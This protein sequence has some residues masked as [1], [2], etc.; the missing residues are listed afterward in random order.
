MEMD[1]LINVSLYG[2]GSRRARLRAE[3]IYCNHANECSAYKDG[4][5]FRVTTLFG[6]RC[7]FGRISCVD[8]CTK[9][10]KTY[11]KVY[12]ETKA[13][14]KYG[15]LSYPYDTYIIR[16]GDGAFLSLPYVRI[17]ESSDGKLICSDPGFG[18]NRL[19]VSIDKLTPENIRRICLYS[20]YALMGGV[21]ADYQKKTVPMFL[22]QLSHLFPEQFQAFTSAY[23]DYKIAPPNWI[24]KY[25]MLSTCNRDVEYE[26]E[27]RNVFHF[28][29]D[30]IVCDHYKSALLSFDI[31]EATLRAKVTDEMRVKITNNDQVTDKTIFV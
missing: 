30:E 4:K 1:E 15:K 3:Y 9:Q 12:A 28:D 7:E 19:F 29:G 17:E 18:S 8:G 24:G 14:E 25:A 10:S 26:D 31:K 2:D 11:H 22:H 21:I 27:R 5:C 16:I 13:H 23:P 6:L 20:P